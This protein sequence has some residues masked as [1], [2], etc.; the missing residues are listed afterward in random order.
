MNSSPDV[1][2]CGAG[3][4]GISCAYHLA[5]KRGVRRIWL[6]DERAPLSLTSDKSSECYRNWWPDQPMVWLMNRSIDIMEELAIQTGNSFQL[7]RRGYLYITADEKQANDW[8]SLAQ[9]ISEYG[10]GPLRIHHGKIDPIPYQPSP[11]E[12][13]DSKCSG[14]D[15]ILDPKILKH[16]FPY[17]SSQAIAALHTRRAGWFSAQQMGMLLLERARANGVELVKA[18]VSGIKIRGGR[19]TSVEL[20]QTRSIEVGRFVN[21]AG[22]FFP[23]LLRLLDAQ[24]LPVINELHLKAVI[25]DSLAV[26]PRNAPLLIWSDP[27]LLTWS[28]EER[29]FLTEEGDTAWMLDELPAGAHTRPEG[30]GGSQMLLMLWEYCVKEME[31]VW[32]LPVD[33]QYAEMTIRGLSKMLPALQGYLNKLPRAVIDGGYYTRT[34][35]NRPLIGP[36]AIE[37]AFACGSFSGYGLM[38]AC[39]AGDLLASYLTQAKL[40]SE[41]SAFSPARYDDP[42]YLEKVKKWGDTGQ[43]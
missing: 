11:D 37:G 6:V 14:A 32:P 38:A 13:F 19:V 1:L 7:N 12:G 39:G 15:L 28:E 9:K 17:I 25:N 10:G 20:D 35:E 40:P 3:I 29:A 5:V 26:V 31:P 23:H 33:P 34:P 41:A 4:A 42:I 22:P 2:I 18:R 24:T 43:L 30:A 27:Q 21:A 36:L 16:H 8:L